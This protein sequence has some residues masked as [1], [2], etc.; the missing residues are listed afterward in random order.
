MIRARSRVVAI[1]MEPS[2]LLDQ[3]YRLNCNPSRS[4]A[5]NHLVDHSPRS[6]LPC[7]IAAAYI[8]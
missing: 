2:Y 3:S 1:L 7:L 5:T 6:K 4:N 8:D